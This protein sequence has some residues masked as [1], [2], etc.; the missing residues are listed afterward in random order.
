[1]LSRSVRRG[2]RSTPQAVMGK[3]ICYEYTQAVKGGLGIASAD[4]ALG[5]SYDVAIPV[6]HHVSYS[7][8]EFPIAPALLDYAEEKCFDGTEGEK[9]ATPCQPLHWDRAFQMVK[10]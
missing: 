6:Y 8:Q 7:A 2:A 3:Q 4:Q 9:G 10:P 1:M 5:L